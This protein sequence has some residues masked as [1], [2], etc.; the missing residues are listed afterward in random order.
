MPAEH[1]EHDNREKSSRHQHVVLRLERARRLIDESFDQPLRLKDIAAAAFMSEAHF[2]RQFHAEFGITPYRCLTERRLLAARRLLEETAM[3]VT[4]I[5]SAAGFGNR[6]AFS[7]LFK[8]RVG[9]SPQAYRQRA[10]NRRPS[11]RASSALPRVAATLSLLITLGVGTGALA[12]EAE[13]PTPP[14]PPPPACASEAHRAFDF[15]IGTWEVYAN[16]QLAGRNEIRST[17]GGCVIQENWTGAGGNFTG[18]SLNLY[19]AA[20]E[21]WHQSWADS[22]GTLLLLEGGI[23]DG[24]MVLEGERPAQDGSGPITHQ[25]TW[26]PGDDGTVRQEW[27]ATRDRKEWRVLFDGEYRRAE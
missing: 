18:S 23:R 8:A 24:S 19:D 25:I 3:P 14:T 15:W 16:D 22:S 27:K 26:T 12:Q 11:R 21:T 6:S 20:R 1:R 7:R 9:L 4:E 17:H 10:R 13:A 5:V 2:V